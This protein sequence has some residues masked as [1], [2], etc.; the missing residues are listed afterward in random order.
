MKEYIEVD[1]HLLDDE[2]AWVVCPESQ[3]KYDKNNWI[4]TF[5]RRHLQ[6]YFSAD[7]I[8]EDGTARIWKN[9]GRLYIVTSWYD[10][11]KLG[12]EVIPLSPSMPSR[13]YG[14]D[15]SADIIKYY[16]SDTFHAGMRIKSGKHIYVGNGTEVEFI[17]KQEEYK[18]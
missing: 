5:N 13:A 15:L 8:A 2:Y 17:P 9:E 12:A 1:E 7:T 18:Q 6:S 16:G 4:R 3:K 11:G 10:A 14:E